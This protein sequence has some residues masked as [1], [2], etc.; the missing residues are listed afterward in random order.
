LAIRV[1]PVKPKANEQ[2]RTQAYSFPADE[3]HQ[4]IVARHQDKHE[5]EEQVHVDE[6]A[7]EIGVAV[8]VTDGINVDQRA[9][10][11]D[12]QHHGHRKRIDLD[13]PRDVKAGSRDLN[14]VKQGDRMGFEITRPKGKEERHGN[15]Q[16]GQG[17]AAGYPA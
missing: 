15:G 13:S 17:H 2:E 14:P 7:R 5:E 1:Y 6:E 10:T 4:V 16:R 9:Y 3:E 8:H 12:N 11:G